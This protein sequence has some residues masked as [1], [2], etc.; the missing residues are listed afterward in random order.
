MASTT[1]VSAP[2]SSASAPVS[3]V[4]APAT[5]ETIKTTTTSS[6]STTG[7]SKEVTWQ[8]SCFD[9][10]VSWARGLY[11]TKTSDGFLGTIAK[12]GY[13]VAA[14]LAFLVETLANGLG[15]PFNLLVSA[16]NVISDS[17]CP[18]EEEKLPVEPPKP[19]VKTEPKKEEKLE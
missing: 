17:C 5:S 3:S 19:E 10:N 7:E 6:L 4:S 15:L 8:N 14:A 18:A 11:E 1:Q 9:L 12:A 2:V 16:K 13:L